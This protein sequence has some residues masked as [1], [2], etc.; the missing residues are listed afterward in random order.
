MR[1]RA[2]NAIVTGGASGIGE[3]TTR[4]LSAEGARVG[5]VDRDVERASAVAAET[6]AVVMGLDLEDLEAIPAAITELATQL[7]DIDLLVNCVGWDRA[8]PF[9]ETDD[10]FWRKVLDINLLGP[11][12]VTHAVLPRIADGGAVVNV[13]S[14]A[15]R[16][17]SSGE[18]VYSG[19]KGGIIAF[20]KAL[21]REV[22]SRRIRVNVVAPGPTDTPFLASFDETG[23][24]AA[25]M[26]RQ[27]PL[28]KLAKPDD[29]A[30]AIVFLGSGDAG[31]ITGQVL[32]VSGGLT[33]V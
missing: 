21:A 3:A 12:A 5:I 7:G 11:I 26:E 10:A 16:V 1:Y 15:G 22:A 2:K 18:V 8:M 13:A 6:G 9:I 27:T 30:S 20:S 32:S 25:A 24:L 33:M 28:R 29:V 17:G 4:R 31:H 23:K 14:D 19:A